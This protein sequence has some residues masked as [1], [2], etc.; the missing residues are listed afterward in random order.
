MCNLHVR[1]YLKNLVSSVA[2]VKEVKEGCNSR[3]N[4][5][6]FCRQAMM[7]YECVS[8]L[9]VKDA[10]SFS[11][12]INGLHYIIVSQNFVA[13]MLT[14]GSCLPSKDLIIGRRYSPIIGQC[15]W[16]TG[17]MNDT[18]SLRRGFF[19]AP[20][21]AGKTTRIPD[22]STLC[23]RVTGAKALSAQCK[24]LKHCYG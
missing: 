9:K 18:A 23:L 11:Y 12:P 8:V 17:E 7:W 22:L 5:T 1:L 4:Y 13:A 3:R 19:T 20:D 14:C 16:R 6:Y 10:S 15:A 2:V 21:D 24:D